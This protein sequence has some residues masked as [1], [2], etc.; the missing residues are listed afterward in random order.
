MPLIILL[1]FRM[2]YI[3][4]EMY[5]KSLQ[6]KDFQN[7]LFTQCLKGI[8]STT[9]EQGGKLIGG[10]TFESRSLVNKPYSLGIEIALTVQGV[11]RNGVKPWLKSGMNDGN[12]VMRDGELIGSPKG[13][14]VT[15]N[16]D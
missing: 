1:Q 2:I 9:E 10:H 7:Y 11:L 8:K 14:P 3:F 15:F 13:K 6:D 12:I 4:I 5:F 16:R